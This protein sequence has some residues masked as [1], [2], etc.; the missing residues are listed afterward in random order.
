[1]Q[2]T[3]CIHGGADLGLCVKKASV[4]LGYTQFGHTLFCKLS[5][6][7]QAQHGNLTAASKDGERD[8][9]TNKGKTA[10]VSS[11]HLSGGHRVLRTGDFTSNRKCMQ[12][13][14]TR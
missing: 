12:V 13:K 1:M 9:E 6:H 14:Q 11:Q 7:A 10:W 3:P 2:M 4:F 5:L 8:I